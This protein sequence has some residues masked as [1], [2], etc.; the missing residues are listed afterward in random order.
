[1]HKLYQDVLSSLWFRPALWMMIYTALALILLE[2]DT[3]LDQATI[4]LASYGLLRT[5]AEGARTMLGAIV[6]AMLTVT[7]LA[8]SLMM[9]AVIQTANA[10]SPR[11]LRRYIADTNNH[12]VLGILI[13]TFLYSMIVLRSVSGKVEYAP[14]IATN[15]AVLLALIATIA[16]VQFL[17]HV[18]QSIKVSS[19]IKLT[20]DRTKRVIE[21][22][23]PRDVGR[24]WIG[25][26]P[27]E[28]PAGPAT[29]IHAKT[30]GYVQIFE[31]DVIAAAREADVIVQMVWRMGDYVLAGTPIAQ[32]WGQVDDAL[33]RAICKGC[34]LG[35]ERTMEQDMAFGLQQ[36]TD[37]ALRALSPGVNDPSTA[38]TA[39]DA[40]SFLIARVIELEQVSPYRCD[41]AGQLRIVFQDWRFEAMIEDTYLRIVQYGG[42]DVLVLAQLLRACEQLSCVATLESQRDSL[43][44]LVE[45]SNA[46]AHVSVGIPAQ[47]RQLDRLFDR[48][49]T[50]LARPPLPA[51]SRSS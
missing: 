24:P 49:R 8:F 23:F 27:P 19:I 5:E 29:P 20:L 47:R 6:T 21:R 46:H 45:A 26:A 17:N 22:G 40:L 12:H 34:V 44:D 33:E 36:L 35:S 50:I 30:S 13:G 11:L 25:D 1:M 43:W 48:T 37:I 31:D 38:A 7:S 4:N 14:F 16:L 10:Y 51:L 32:V 9:V 28:L 2:V 18:P 42:G 15:T 3:R 41:Q 39:I